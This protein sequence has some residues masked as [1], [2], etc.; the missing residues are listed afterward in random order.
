LLC[1]G[2]VFGAL[3]ILFG[4]AIA[5]GG[6]VAAAGW[7]EDELLVTLKGAYP[8]L[9]QDWKKAAFVTH[10]EDHGG[11]ELWIVTTDGSNLEKIYG[12]TEPKW[13]AIVR[14]WSPNGNKILL[15]VFRGEPP[16]SP[17][18]STLWII[19]SDGT[20]MKQIAEGAQPYKMCPVVIW[21]PNGNKIGYEG[22]NGIHVV[23]ADGSDDKLIAGRGLLS[24]TPDSKK[25]IFDSMIIDVESGIQEK[26]LSNYTGDIRSNMVISPDASKVAYCNYGIWVANIKG[27]NPRQLTYSE[28][29]RWIYWSPDSKRLAFMNFAEGIRKGTWVMNADGSNQKKITKY[30][31]TKIVWN[32]DGSKIAYA[33]YDKKN[34]T[35]YI[36]TINVG[37]PSHIKPPTCET[38]TEN[39]PGISGFEALFAFTG[40][41]VVTYFLRRMK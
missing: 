27:S 40:L 13:A 3:V 11:K 20:G 33:V 25:I 4:A 7:D 16:E 28:M 14:G 17:S 31:L 41:L 35:T 21:S 1:K 24:W 18:D 26:I 12:W 2:L 19:N 8:S 30:P 34:A 6:V 15:W 32:Q 38:P 5:S 9:S 23:N 29:D 39:Q 22:Y 37:K 36:Y 10:V